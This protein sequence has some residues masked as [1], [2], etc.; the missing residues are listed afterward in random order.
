M[1]LEWAYWPVSRQARLAEQVERGAEGLAEEH[2][3]LGE[4][5]DPRRRDRVAVRLHVATRVVRVQVEDVGRLHAARGQMR[6]AMTPWYAAAR[7]DL[8]PEPLDPLLV[9]R[10]GLARHLALR[11]TSARSAFDPSE[12]DDVDRGLLV[13]L[14]ELLVHDHVRRDPARGEE[15]HPLAV[16]LLELL[17]QVVDRGE[18]VAQVV[19]DRAP[20]PSS[21]FH[22][23]FWIAFHSETAWRPCPGG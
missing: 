3:L 23:Q 21:R 18:V 8:A 17:H 5:L 22:V 14:G 9:Q 11:R 2:A 1:P 6:R 10:V 4:A 7:T 12:R 16:V 19:A 15:L 20:S 13:V